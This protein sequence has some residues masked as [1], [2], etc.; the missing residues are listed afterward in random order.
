MTDNFARLLAIM[1]G[2]GG[3]SDSE[4]QVEVMPEADVGH[5]G[6]IRQYVGATTTN[7]INGYFYK[8]ESETNPDTGT[9]TY[10]WIA[11]D[12]QPE[13]AKHWIGTRA[14]LTVALANG[15]IEDGTIILI[16]DE[17]DVDNLPTENSTN[18]VYSG[19][20]WTA[21][22]EVVSDISIIETRL[23][24]DLISGNATTS[25]DVEITVEANYLEN[26]D[27]AN[28]G[29]S[30]Q[31]NVWGT[32]T[33]T[34]LNGNTNILWTGARNVKTFSIVSVEGWLNDTFKHP[35][36]PEYYLTSFV[37]TQIWH[38]GAYDTRSATQIN[39]MIGFSIYFTDIDRNLANGE[40]VTDSHGIVHSKDVNGDLTITYPDGY[41]NVVINYEYYDNSGYIIQGGD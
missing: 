10:S 37:P 6:E 33:M 5:L 19:G 2:V 18:L 40:S 31:F 1:G 26:N 27:Y 29:Y 34:S 25:Y 3:G 13:G 39:G 22:Q 15:D 14:E 24:N 28:V 35:F 16:T 41:F 8:C 32:H 7:Y 4:I 21:L 30:F 36:I 23:K 11:I 12:T 9:T 38:D 20:V 17:P